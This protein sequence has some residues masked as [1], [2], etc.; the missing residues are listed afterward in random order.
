MDIAVTA[1][2]VCGV[3][4]TGC[5]GFGLVLPFVDGGTVVLFNRL[6]FVL[7]ILRFPKV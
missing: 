6:E 1:A 4:K 5:L 7:C 3:Y 2:L